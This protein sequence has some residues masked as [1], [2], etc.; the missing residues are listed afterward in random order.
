L[1][2]REFAALCACT[3]R[4]VS[5]PQSSAGSASGLL[6]RI[7]HARPDREADPRFIL[8]S[9]GEV[10]YDWDLASDQIVW[11]PNA[12][13]V[14]GSP[15]LGE[16]QSGLAW[17]K[18]VAPSSPSSRYDAILKSNEADMGTGVRYQIEYGIMPFGRGVAP[19]WVEDTGRWFAATDGRPARAHGVLRIVDERHEDDRRRMLASRFDPLTGAMN[20]AQLIDHIDRTFSVSTRTRGQ[21]ALML[22]CI[23]NLVQLNRT[24]GYETADTIIAGVADRLRSTLRSTDVIARYAGNKFALVLDNCDGAQMAAAA[25]RCLSTIAAEPFGAANGPVQVSVRIGGIIAPR[26]A[27]N[28]Q[29]LLQRAEEALEA[30]RRPAGPH[31]VA[32]TPSLGKDASRSR[33]RRVSDQIVSALNDQRIQ[34]ALEPIVCAKTRRPVFHEALLRMRLEDGTIAAPAA[35]IPT[36]E[37]T[38]LIALVDQRVLEIAVSKLE[39]DPHLQVSVNMSGATTRDADWTVRIGALVCGRPDLAARL[40]IEITETCAIADLD[41]AREAFATLRGL[42]IKI[43][44]DDFGAGHTSFR[45]LRMLGIDIVKIDGAFIQNLARSVDDRFFVRTLIELAGHLGIPTVAE[46]VEDEETARLLGE[47]GVDYFQGSLFERCEVLDESRL[48]AV[49]AA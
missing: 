5:V 35:I 44:M 37:E 22:A 13:E 45:N 31:F 15:A 25:L 33:T 24:C 26:Q 8:S 42:G 30:S 2:F 29:A 36:A 19:V 48:D 9:I 16:I 49:A 4:R 3:I 14:L 34:I 1:T 6:A 18:R 17:M 7:Q 40:T 10:V 32:F 39:A 46:W 11:G 28:H 20:R 47:W 12:A 23:D 43:A 38:G 21:F 41:N 27:R